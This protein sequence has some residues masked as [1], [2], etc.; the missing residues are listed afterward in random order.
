MM[1]IIEFSALLTLVF[2]ALV[3]GYKFGKN[4]K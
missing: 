2:T 3:V 4:A 1:T